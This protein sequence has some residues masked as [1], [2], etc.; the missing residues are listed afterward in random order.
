[1]TV[2]ERH[3]MHRDPVTSRHRA[4]YQALSPWFAGDCIDLGGGTGYGATII[5]SNALV[6]SV[7][8]IDRAQVPQTY[9]PQE[10]R[11]SS[12]VGTLPD[13]LSALRTECADTVTAVEFIEHIGPHDQL[14]LVREAHRLLRSG[15]HLLLS[16]PSAE[17]SGPN[18]DNQ[19]HV[20]E[21][22]REDGEKLLTAGMFQ[23]VASYEANMGAL[24]DGKETPVAF[25]V[26]RKA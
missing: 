23:L 19:W 9:V 14:R 18:P 8:T 6:R 3:D 22:T 11:T 16:M 1:M 17:K 5:G 26:G 2:G 7:L 13:C 4:R 10:V 15:G 21:L 25:L 20:W 24:T 12:M